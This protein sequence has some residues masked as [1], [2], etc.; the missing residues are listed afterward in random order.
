METRQR[1]TIWLI[2]FDDRDFVLANA[3]ATVNV[4]RSISCYDESKYLM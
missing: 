2:I 3:D 4:I 1:F